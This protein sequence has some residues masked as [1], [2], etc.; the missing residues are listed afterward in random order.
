VKAAELFD[1]NRDLAN[2]CLDHAFVQ[3]IAS[4]ALDRDAFAFYVGQDAAFLEAFVRAYAL[5]LA[6]APDRAA[7][8]AFTSL[9]VGAQEELRLHR[10]YAERW[11]VDLHPEVA[12]TTSAYTDFLLRVAALE[13]AAHVCAAMTPC[14]RLYAW[15]GQ[16]LAPIAKE[17]SPYLEWVQTYSDDALEQLARTLEDLLDRLPGDGDVIASHYR[18]AMRLELAFFDAALTAGR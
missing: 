12:P 6:R 1:A 11:G 9:L 7:M 13:P 5:G 10:G 14:M 8:D 2:A 16:S 18:T 17:E 15:L 3:G 4:G